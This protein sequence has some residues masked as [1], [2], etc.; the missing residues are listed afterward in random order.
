[1]TTIENDQKAVAKGWWESHPEVPDEVATWAPVQFEDGRTAK[2]LGVVLQRIAA[3]ASTEEGS[4][5][6]NCVEVQAVDHLRFA[7][8]N[9]HILGVAE[10]I[11]GFPSDP[12][13]KVK[14]ATILARPALFHRSDILEVSKLLRRTLANGN[15]KLTFMRHG[16]RRD[17]VV[18]NGE[19]D[20]VVAHEQSVEFPD[21]RNSVPL[22]MDMGKAAFNG[23]YMVWAGELCAAV[24]GEMRFL[25]MC[26]RRVAL[27][28][29]TSSDFRCLAA[30]MPMFIQWPAEYSPRE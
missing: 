23:R 24:G 5:G 12:D 13:G 10:Y 30:V 26:D 4:P 27:I 7:A 25:R 17:M 15:A 9:R 14:A 3:A 1:M 22:E 6:F 11:P 21:W 28:E 20:E 16:E 8:T 18:S 19:G 29:A 2:K